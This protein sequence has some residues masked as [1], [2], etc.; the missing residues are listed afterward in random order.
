MIRIVVAVAPVYAAMD[1]K[2][3]GEMAELAMKLIREGFADK[4]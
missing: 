2:V 1:R 3:T 4:P